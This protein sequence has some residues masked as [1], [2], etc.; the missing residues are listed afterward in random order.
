MVTY[1]NVEDLC[2]GEEAGGSR[3][4]RPV[5]LSTWGGGE[6]RIGQDGSHKA[7]DYKKI[8]QKSMQFEQCSLSM[9]TYSMF[10]Y[11]VLHII[12]KVHI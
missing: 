8:S 2:S 4:Q 12:E 10:F 5:K 6:V 7:M 3:G 11:P 9:F 1:E